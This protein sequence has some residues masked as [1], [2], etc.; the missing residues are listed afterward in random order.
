MEA[1]HDVVT[2]SKTRDLGARRCGRA[3]RKKMQQAAATNGS[4]R[5]IAVQN[6]YSLMQR[7]EERGMF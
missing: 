2:A 6:P 5:F 1:L 4:T 7:E 3:I